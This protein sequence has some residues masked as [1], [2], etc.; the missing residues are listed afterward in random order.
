MNSL[1][2]AF[3]MVLMHTCQHINP[4][5]HIHKTLKFPQTLKLAILL[6]QPMTGPSNYSKGIMHWSD[7]SYVAHFV[8]QAASAFSFVTP[9]TN[10]CINF[11]KC[12]CLFV[13]NFLFEM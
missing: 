3:I 8:I 2:D 11:Y 5:Y 9:P 1:I 6:K 4:F 7:C 12:V 13:L 10:A